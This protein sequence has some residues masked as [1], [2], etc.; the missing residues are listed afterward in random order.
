MISRSIIRSLWLYRQWLS[1]IY[2]VEC[3]GALYKR[4]R[5]EQR[6]EWCV[7]FPKMYPIL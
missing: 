1:W 4:S 2:Y 3:N 6:W 5:R 7:P